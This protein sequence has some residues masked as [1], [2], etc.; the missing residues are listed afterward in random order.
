MMRGALTTSVTTTA[1][2]AWRAA[3]LFAIA[4]ALPVAPVAAQNAAGD[5]LRWQQRSAQREQENLRARIATLQ[6]Q[7]DAREAA[8]KDATD[9][10]RASER[11]LSTLN[12]Q[13]AKL[14]R[15]VEAARKK[16]A[17][18]QADIAKQTQALAERR[19]ALASQ[20]RAQ[21]ATGLSP[22]AALFSG[23][24][25]HAQGRQ[26]A[27]LDY[28]SRARAQEVESLRH[29]IARLD[30]LHSEA[31]AQNDVLQ[32]LQA[33]TAQR[34]KE[35]QA[36]QRTHATVLARLDGQ[37]QAQRA[38]NERLAR[39]DERL[40]KLLTDLTR[41][42]EALRMEA[43][44]AAAKAAEKAA[45]SARRNGAQNNAQNNATATS[46]SSKPLPAKLPMPVA[47]RITARFGSEQPGGGTWRGVV[48][49]APVGAPVKAVADGTVVYGDWL[50]GFGNLIIIDHGAE[51]L[52]VYAYNQ[53]LLKEVGDRVGAG[54]VI[55]H[56]GAT[57][58]QA[59]SGLY[60]EIRREGAPQDPAKFFAR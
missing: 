11:A 27:Y 48:I 59:E 35:Q 41:Q 6:R 30:A 55:A 33:E 14:N 56:V 3:A 51:F 12:R 29:A 46:T 5:D 9:A 1:R 28:V 57:G 34:Q 15:D 13:L 24:N 2:T 42:L 49:K 22:W 47:G 31:R 60:F 37:L 19:A 40:S 20:L 10:L 50:R 43:E 32:K 39:D 8:R 7:I 21:Y 25:P 44:K 4:L 36:Q 52:S 53:S 23:E 38:E 17:A 45:T 18:L 54:E 16:L 58:G 26:L